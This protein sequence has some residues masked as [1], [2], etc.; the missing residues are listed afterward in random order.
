MEK[1]PEELIASNVAPH[2]D[3]Q[4]YTNTR[5]PLFL[6]L[7]YLILPFWGFYFLI[8]YWNGSTG[9]TDRGA[10]HELQVAANTTSVISPEEPQNPRPVMGGSLYK[11]TDS[12]NN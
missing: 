10:W 7:T 6:K 9:W 11:L 4:E 1:K 8:V 5:V 3:I 2:L 12:K